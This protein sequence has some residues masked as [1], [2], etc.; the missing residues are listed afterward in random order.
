MED[1]PG[2]RILLPLLLAAH[3]L[4]ASTAPPDGQATLDRHVQSLG[5]EAR[6]AQKLAEFREN[7]SSTMPVGPVRSSPPELS[8]G[9]CD[10]SIIIPARNDGHAGG[11]F[12]KRLIN[13]LHT[14][15]RLGWDGLDV[16]AEVIVVDWATSKGKISLREA[17]GYGAACDTDQSDSKQCPYHDP[18]CVL[19]FMVIPESWSSGLLNPLGHGVMQ[20][21]AKNI[22]IRR[23]S[24]R[25]VRTNRCCAPYHCF[26][27]RPVAD[28]VF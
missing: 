7:L 8:G 27:A 23:A 15:S 9:G 18:G 16:S 24:G 28:H 26:T 21:M 11:S 1:C 25:Y 4:L 6:R 22:A 19:R 17:L 14:I 13:C 20:Y 5:T 10:V 2:R 3:F 12:L